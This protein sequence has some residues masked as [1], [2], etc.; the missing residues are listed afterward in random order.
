[1]RRRGKARGRKQEEI[2]GRESVVRR[3]A[4][5]RPKRRGRKGPA[6]LARLLMVLLLLGVIVGVVALVGSALGGEPTC[7]PTPA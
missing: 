5:S 3:S 4:R 2:E 1:M 6:P 7:V